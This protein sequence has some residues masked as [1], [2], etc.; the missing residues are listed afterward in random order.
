MR[1]E[2]ADLRLKRADL[3]PEKANLR[4]GRADLRPRIVFLGGDMAKWKKMP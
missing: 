1:P 4:L 3:R 2:R